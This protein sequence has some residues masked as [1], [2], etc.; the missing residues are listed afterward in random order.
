MGTNYT[1]DAN[2][3][4]TTVGSITSTS[5]TSGFLLPRMTTTQRNLIPTPATGLEIFNTTTNQIEFYNGSIWTS[6]GGTAGVTGSGSISTIPK[7]TASTV[8][9]NSG[10]GDNGPGN[11]FSAGLIYS[12]P[13]SGQNSP[14]FTYLDGS[15]GEQAQE[16]F[17]GHTG[18]NFS[19][20]TNMMTMPQYNGG[21]VIVHGWE[22]S[23]FARTFTDVINMTAHTSATPAV[24]SVLSSVTTGSPAPVARTYTISQRTLFMQM[25][26]NSINYNV[27][28]KVTNVQ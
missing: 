17:T 25:S 23:A 26:G 16:S 8:L 11:Q 14:Y 15:T 5:T 6:V 22:L 27:G 2:G 18:S 7:W 28:V 3:N 20:A 4:I 21:L 24:F 1:V 13:T 9:G 12:N 10:L 19:A